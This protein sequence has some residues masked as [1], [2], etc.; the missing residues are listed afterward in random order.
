MDSPSPPSLPPSQTH[1]LRDTRPHG[2][3]W[4]KFFGW[5]FE[6][7]LSEVISSS[8]LAFMLISVR[9]VVRFQSFP[10]ATQVELIKAS[11]DPVWV[12][13]RFSDLR[14]VAHCPWA[15]FFTLPCDLTACTFCIVVKG[16]QKNATLKAV[17][18]HTSSFVEFLW[19]ITWCQPCLYKSLSLLPTML[20]RVF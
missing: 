19:D 8:L 4:G 15:C 3:P 9:P 1:A 2:S 13:L 17:N 7:Q 5:S 12:Q 18:L 6:G 16:K 20:H 11:E 14:W 10:P